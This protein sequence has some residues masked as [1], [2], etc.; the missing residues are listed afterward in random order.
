MRD[1]LIISGVL[2]LLA[3]VFLVIAARHTWHIELLNHDRR[4]DR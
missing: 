4:Q 3:L 1:L 2:G